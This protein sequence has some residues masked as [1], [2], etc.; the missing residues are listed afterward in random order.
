[1]QEE[2]CDKTQPCLKT[3]FLAAAIDSYSE[4][5]S[6]RKSSPIA[7][8]DRADFLLA[9]AREGEDAVVVDFA[10][11]EEKSN[12]AENALVMH[13]LIFS[14]AGLLDLPLLI[15]VIVSKVWQ[16]KLRFP[17]SVILLHR[18]WRILLDLWLLKHIQP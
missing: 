12:V 13:P 17:V 6:L 16:Q 9:L 8:L 1:M 11:L 18:P 7:G 5:R 14:H 3:P 15:S 10:E 4:A 2:I